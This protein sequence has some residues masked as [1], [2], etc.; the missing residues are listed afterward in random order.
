M[1]VYMYVCVHIYTYIYT[2]NNGTHT[3]IHGASYMLQPTHRDTPSYTHRRTHAHTH[4]IQ[5]ICGAGSAYSWGVCMDSCALIHTGMHTP[6]HGN[7]HPNNQYACACSFALTHSHRVA[8]CL[9]SAC[10]FF[11]EFLQSDLQNRQRG[12]YWWWCWESPTCQ[13]PW[14]LDSLSP[15]RQRCSPNCVCE[16][17]CAPSLFSSGAYLHLWPSLFF[18]FA[19]DDVSAHSWSSM[20]W[21]RPLVLACPS[22]TTTRQICR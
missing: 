21:E 16:H 8:V 12:R 10:A 2:Y 11:S 6:I 14:V 3:F 18:S 22:N 7:I 9:P 5:R 20:G 17:V 13:S 19:C 4:H 15:T 1:H